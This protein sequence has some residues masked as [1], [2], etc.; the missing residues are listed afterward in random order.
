MKHLS[1]AIAFLFSLGSI[2][3]NHFFGNRQKSPVPAPISKCFLFG[4]NELIKFNLFL[5]AML[6]Q[7]DMLFQ[8]LY[9]P[10][11]KYNQRFR[12]TFLNFLNW[13]ASRNQHV[14]LAS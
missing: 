12:S 13:V 10:Y 9:Y 3:Y 4:C 6:L 2:V 7:N 8:I 14:N 11:A 5:S 1:F